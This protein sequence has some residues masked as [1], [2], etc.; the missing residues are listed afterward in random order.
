[1]LG[2][3][4]TALVAALAPFSV[5]AQTTASPTPAS[6]PASV[7]ATPV[8]RPIVALGGAVNP[9]ANIRTFQG[10]IDPLIGNIRTFNGDLTPYIGNIRTFSGELNPYIGNIRTFWGGLAPAEGELDPLIGNIR[11]FW[12][13]FSVGSKTTLTAW[14]NIRTF[15]QAPAEYQALAGSLNTMITQSQQIYGPA[16]QARTGLSF[17][18]GFSNPLLARYGIDLSRPETLATLSPGLRQ[19]FFLDWYDGLMNFSGMDQVDHWMTE[20]NWSPSITATIGEGKRSIIG[21]LDFTVTGD[22]TKNITR[23][24]GISNF[25]NG[26]G[27]AVAS[28]MIAAHDGRG[29]MGIAPMASVVAYNPFDSSGTA[30]WDDVR[31]GVLMLAQNNASIINM[32]LG[33]PGSTL[34]QGWN[35]VFADPAVAAATKSS[36]FVIAA[37][38][39]GSTQT[40]NVAWNFATNPNLI[41]VGSV[42][43]TGT[44]SAFSNR[45]GTACLTNNGVCSAGNRLMDRFLVAPG[46]MILVSDGLGGVTRVSGTSF[47]AP[48]VSGT[49]ALLHDRW[50]W[51]ANYPK[52]SVDII[53]RSAKDLGA[54]G[55]DPIYGRGELDVTAALS[56]LSFEG[57]KWY[58]YK[59]GKISETQAK[60]IRNPKEVAKWEAAGMFFYAYEDIGNSF[61]DFAI[62]M[63]SKLVGQTALSS[64][65]TMEQLQAYI[66]S[67]FIAWIGAGGKAGQAGPGFVGALSFSSPVQTSGGLNYSMAIAPRTPQ[68]GFRQPNVPYQSAVRFSVPDGRASFTMGEG[69]GAIVLGS[70]NGTGIASD[71]NPYTGGSN[72]L[73]GFAS[74]GGYG[75]VAISIGDRVK[76]SSG[77]SQR[78]LVRDVRQMS[79]PDRIDFGSIAPYQASAQTFSVSYTMSYAVQLTGTYTR[80]EEGSALLGTQSIDPADL[81]DGSITEGASL[82]AEVRL[83]PTLLLTAT[84]M[85]AR[86]NSGDSARQSLAVSS[87]G[88]ISSAFQVSGTKR[89]ILNRNDS[90]RFTVS[91]PMHMESGAIDFT[92]VKVVNRQ[93]GELGPVTQRIDLVSPERQFIGEATYGMAVMDGAAEVRLF[94]QAT[95][96]GPTTELAPAVMA[97]AGFRLAL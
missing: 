49:I 46:E 29:V 22:G 10:D 47:A 37:G 51:L 12:D 26:H 75:Q 93:T 17:A 7:P 69:D 64:G 3:A 95:L 77:F 9:L 85:M 76:V 23:Y 1:M 92:A 81:R 39:D 96:K 61:R 62:P 94:G 91:Q 83:T 14:A 16:V 71:Y 40:Q 13:S 20:V 87:G 48:L 90:I 44:I 15:D 30:N 63:S 68:V 8:A 70:L 18:A 33:V 32:S 56:P 31:N 4:I 60:K 24:N 73:L 52:E 66:Y 5:G 97:G 41:V 27:S 21:L 74:G 72:P 11:T 53:L 80:L 42:D 55:V 65:G 84:G 38:N 82:G 67:R 6:T 25:T 2:G 19:Q 89:K 88:L 58:E 35:D 28:L 43:P 34:N 79:I 36:V 86:T 57:L 50:P 54:P 45:P 78:K 59:D